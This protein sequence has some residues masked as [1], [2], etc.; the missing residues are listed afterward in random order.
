MY[1]AEKRLIRDRKFIE[2]IPEKHF[3]R[4]FSLSSSPSTVWDLFPPPKGYRPY[5]TNSKKTYTV[6]LKRQQSDW[7]KLVLERDNHKCQ[8]CGSTEKLEA[9][10]IWPQGAY[11]NLRYLLRNGITLCRSCHDVAYH[12]PQ[13]TPG[14]FIELTSE[15][16]LINANIESENF[17]SYY[18]AGA[19]KGR[20]LAYGILIAEEMSMTDDELNWFLS[21]AK[22][23]NFVARS[24]ASASEAPILDAE[25][26]ISEK[27]ESAIEAFDAFY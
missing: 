9:H 16:T 12:A 24:R 14:Q 17:W 7:S 13:I 23:N 25:Y 19:E 4:A 26:H 15:V 3:A 8:K 10:H 5:N 22:L 1:R 18:T 11:E 6:S 2:Y 20:V 27:I 21:C